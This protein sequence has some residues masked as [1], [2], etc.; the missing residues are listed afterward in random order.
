M[1]GSKPRPVTVIVAP[2]GSRPDVRLTVIRGSGAAL[3][4]LGVGVAD[5]VGFGVA[6]AVG[7]RVVAERV[8]A[9]VGD[10]GRVLAEP[11]GRWAD[12]VGDVVGRPD[13][14]A[15]PADVVAAGGSSPAGAVGEVLA[16]VLELD[17]AGA[18][19]APES[20]RASVP[21]PARS[22]AAAAA[23]RGVATRGV[24]VRRFIDVLR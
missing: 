5:D 11:L 3:D 24:V 19:A 16:A 4:E 12:A 14:A 20:C 2:S 10:A 9:G 8:G 6:D 13:E 23:T 22:S 1:A 7:V 21:Q 18:A 15:G 17:A